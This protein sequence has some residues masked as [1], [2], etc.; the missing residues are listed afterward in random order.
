MMFR[1]LLLVERVTTNNE[2]FSNPKLDQT[3]S[4]QKRY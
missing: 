4:G 1:A 3:Q 2:A